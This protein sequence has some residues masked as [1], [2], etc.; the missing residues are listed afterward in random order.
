M[1]GLCIQSNAGNR[2][3]TE[4]SQQS[5]HL[6]S[7]QNERTIALIP[8]SYTEFTVTRTDSTGTHIHVHTDEVDLTMRRPHPCDC[9]GRP[10]SYSHTTAR[11]HAH[12][13]R[14]HVHTLSHNRKSVPK[15]SQSI[16]HLQGRECD[17]NLLDLPFSHRCTLIHPPIHPHPSTHEGS[18]ENGA[19]GPT[20]HV[21]KAELLLQTLLSAGRPSKVKPQNWF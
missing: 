10:L 17:L 15:R 16:A 11:H 13:S 4:A 5:A 20:G 2:L 9:R 21:F 14:P 3:K 6:L 1:N 7:D 8:H 18:I 19:A 12:Q